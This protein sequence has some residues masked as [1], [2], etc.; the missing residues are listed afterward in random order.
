M[1]HA[2][3]LEFKHPITGENMHFEAPLPEYFEEVLEKLE[4]A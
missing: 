3:E 1:L 4:Q 2:K